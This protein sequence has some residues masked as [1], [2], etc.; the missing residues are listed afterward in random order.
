[1][2]R[3]LQRLFSTGLL[4]V[5]VGCL[6]ATAASAEIAQTRRSS[7]PP[8]VIQLEIDGPIGPAT[9]DYVVRMLERAAQQDAA[10]V[11]LRMDTPGGLDTAM[12]VIIK[13]I[14]ASTV[15]VAT[16][17]APSGARA[18]S[19]GTY[20]LYASHLAAMA[21]ATNLGAATP[22]QIGMPKGFGD[23]N[24]TPT[25]DK[26]DRPP[27]DTSP[28][29]K[30]ATNDAVAYIRGLAHLRG[31]NA[32]WAEQAVRAAASL[33]AEEALRLHVIDVVATDLTDLLQQFDG[34]QLQVLG[35]TR[36]LQL[37]GAN[38]ELRTPDWRSRLLAA[39]ANPNVA[40]ILMLIGIYGL[41]IEFYN[42]GTIA[43]GTIGAIC[44]LLALYAFQALPVNYAGVALILL[45]IGLMVAEA[46]APGFGVLGLGGTAAFVFGSVIL[47]DSTTPGLAVHPVLI[48]VVAISSAAFLILVTGALLKARTKPVVSGREEML[49]STGIAVADFTTRGSIRIHGETWSARTD[50]PLCKGQEVVVR[51]MDGLTLVVSPRNTN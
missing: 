22:I 29:E 2:L 38:V 36:Q 25:G 8:Q 13:N 11:V 33:P 48:T 50:T 42:P 31:R 44:L 45:G 28:Q 18:A 3:G 40:Y 5:F 20:I 27:P 34:R 30:K 17:V 14:L 6:L 19:A 10:L 26:A 49:G 4:F 47:V 37:A 24:R 12:R 43:P 51:E 15:P 41:V 46:F 23:P 32:D 35:Q 7:H 9:S 1:M 39:I 16:Y 21:P